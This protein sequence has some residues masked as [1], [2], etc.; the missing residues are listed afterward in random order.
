M[1]KWENRFRSLQ[2]DG[3]KFSEISAGSDIARS[4]PFGQSGVAETDP[5][6][7][8]PGRVRNNPVQAPQTLRQILL[9]LT[10]SRFHR[11]FEE[12]VKV[13]LGEAWTTPPQHAPDDIVKP[14]LV[15]NCFGACIGQADRQIGFDP[16]DGIAR[17]QTKQ[18]YELVQP[19]R[20]S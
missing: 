20:Q 18:Q 19:F 7:G 14:A 17:P 6:I 10:N 3:R 1:P 16:S 15:V 2:L 5:A 8:R 13:E 12:P 4:P 11:I 9:F